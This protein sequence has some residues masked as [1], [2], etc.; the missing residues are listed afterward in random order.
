MEQAMNKHFCL[1]PRLGDSRDPVVAAK[2][3]CSPVIVAVRICEIALLALNSWDQR[4]A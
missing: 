3:N 2:N 1:L 4:A